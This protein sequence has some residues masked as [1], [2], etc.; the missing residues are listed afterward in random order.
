MITQNSKLKGQNQNLN[1]RTELK[2]RCYYFS[3]KVIKFIEK[4]P[5][6]RFAL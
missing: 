4:I 6:M 1:Q 5:Q 2:Y 3:I